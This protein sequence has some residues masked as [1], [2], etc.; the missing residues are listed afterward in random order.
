MGTLI[1]EFK[2]LIAPDVLPCPDPIVQRELMS[3]ILDFCR[4]TNIL[5]RDFELEIDADEIDEDLQDS[6]DFDISEWS[7][8]LR[9]TSVLEIV[10]DTT[11]F[12]PSAR[13]IRNT[14]TQ[15]AALNDER[16]IYFWIPDDHTVR[17]F[18]LNSNL[19]RIWM[20]IAVKPLRDSIEVDD[21]LFED[22][23]EPIVAGTKYNIMSMPG[24]DWTDFKAADVYNRRYRR[25]MSRAKAYVV[26][27]AT[28]V[29]QETVHWKSFGE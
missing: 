1:T 4:N 22:W 12:V 16:K 14:H 24:K 8:D 3:V 15:F 23:S 27:G 25:G 10:I 18:N 19:S 7:N 17:V 20:N 6:I 26:R 5:Q 9:P 13:N 11:P 28:G 29:Y 2:N 21:E